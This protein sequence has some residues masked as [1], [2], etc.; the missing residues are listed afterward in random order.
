MR[1]AFLLR[2]WPYYGGGETVTRVLIEEF[3]KRGIDIHVLY[4]WNR[5]EGRNFNPSGNY[6]EY[7]FNMPESN[8]YN[9]EGD[10]SWLK[11]ELTDYL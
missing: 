4:W 9:P 11:D 7:K 10:I 6:Y 1:I 2:Y 3:L 8:S 5:N